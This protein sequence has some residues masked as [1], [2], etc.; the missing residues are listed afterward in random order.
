MINNY[1]S[2]EKHKVSPRTHP[3]KK[4][5]FKSGCS[6]AGCSSPVCQIIRE[7][8]YTEW[9]MSFIE[10]LNENVFSQFRLWLE[11]D[12]NNNNQLS[13]TSNNA[14]GKRSFNR[15]A[16]PPQINFIDLTK[17]AL[18]YGNK[19]IYRNFKLRLVIEYPLSSPSSY[20]CSIRDEVAD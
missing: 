19:K 17:A 15:I 14:I 13:T 8:E 20:C 5:S 1:S 12:V 10:Y 2:K 7:G 4:W 11:M 18:D 16:V 9:L 3:H 6:C